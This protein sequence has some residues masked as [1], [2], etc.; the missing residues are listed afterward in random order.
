VNSQPKEKNLS[1]K[2]H[3][4]LAQPSYPKVSLNPLALQTIVI[5]GLP[6]SIDSKSLWK[7]VRKLDGVEKLEWPAKSDDGEEDSN[8]GA[9]ASH[10]H[11]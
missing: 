3:K 5:S 9:H 11:R 6:C 4:A 10:S 8:S 1:K 2:E 7:K